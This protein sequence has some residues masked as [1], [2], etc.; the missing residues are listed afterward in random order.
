M[1]EN[2]S[3]RKTPGTEKFT[4]EFLSFKEKINFTQ[5]LSEN[6]KRENTLHFMR[7]M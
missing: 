3:L 7:L 1:F 4:D 2:L 5:T 6:K